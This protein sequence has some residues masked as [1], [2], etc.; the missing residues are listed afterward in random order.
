MKVAVSL[1]AFWG[2]MFLLRVKSFNV[3]RSLRG[4]FCEL[5]EIPHKLA[6]NIV[7]EKS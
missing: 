3:H 7:G 6:P 2:T 5:L 1:I 4:R